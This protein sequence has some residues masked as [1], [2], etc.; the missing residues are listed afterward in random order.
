MVSESFLIHLPY[1]PLPSPPLT[2]YSL[3]LTPVAPPLPHCSTPPITPHP[4]PPTC[5][6]PHP[7]I[8]IPHPLPLSPRVELLFIIVV[9]ILCSFLNFTPSTNTNSLTS[10]S[11]PKNN[12]WMAHLPRCH[13]QI[14]MKVLVNF[15]IYL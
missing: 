13:N 4:S 12:G 7:L 1:T 2:P 3:P 10:N 6:G 9:H 5:C 11:D 15:Y 14:P 8:L